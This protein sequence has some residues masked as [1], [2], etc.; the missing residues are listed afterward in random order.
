[1]W[2]ISSV[3]PEDRGVR[4]G[5]GGAAEAQVQRAVAAVGMA[6]RHIDRAQEG[7]DTGPHGRAVDEVV[8]TRLGAGGPDV[9]RFDPTT[10]VDATAEP[11]GQ[12]SRPDVVA[13]ARHAEERAPELAFLESRE[14]AEPA[15]REVVV[16]RNLRAEVGAAI[17]RHVDPM[18]P[19][20][21]HL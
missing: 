20:V 21:E 10:Q 5:E 17:D 18:P 11:A 4:A 8:E 16:E 3:A 9:P 7:V 6:V 13:E 14:G 19:S 2:R 12:P 15:H 1:D